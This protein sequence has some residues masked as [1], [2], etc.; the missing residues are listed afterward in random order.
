MKKQHIPAYPA[1]VSKKW[2][3]LL[4]KAGWTADRVCKEYGI[5]RKTLYKWIKKDKESP[6]YKSPKT[7]PALKLTSE[8]RIYIEKQKKLTKAGLKKLA[9]MVEKEFEVKV[10]STIVYRFLKKSFNQKIAKVT[11]LV[12]S[13]ERKNHSKSSGR[14]YST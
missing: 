3:F 12:Y 9:I 7:Q 14:T 11:P 6:I 4:Y 1:V 2:S 13:N 5:S 8:I 10:S